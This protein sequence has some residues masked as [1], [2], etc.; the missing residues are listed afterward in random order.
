MTASL[1][2]KNTYR[3]AVICALVAACIMAAKTP[4]SKVLLAGAD[5]M[6]A[7]VF[8]G[9]GAALGMLIVMFFARNTSLVDKTRHLQKSDIPYLCGAILTSIGGSLFLLFGLLDAAASTASL[10]NNFGT[11]ATAV[12]AFLI[13]KEGISKR[14]CIGIVFTV[15]GC[16]ALSVTD[17][18]TLSF[19]PGS[20]LIILS[21]I[22]YGFNNNFM[23]KISH[24]NPVEIVIVRSGG[25]AVGCLI[26][27]F[28][29]GSAMPS[30]TTIALLAATGFV[31]SG[32][33]NFFVVYAQRY[34]GAA[35]TSAIT[36]IAPL[37]SVLICFVFLGEPLSLL[38]AGALIL[39][40]PGMY[41]TLTRNKEMKLEE[42]PEDKGESPLL[43]G[44]SEATKDE[45]RHYLMAF[46]FISLAVLHIMALFSSLT[47]SAVDGKILSVIG[48]GLYS[49]CSVIGIA[50][51]L[52]SIL[53]LILRKRVIP[54]ILFM[55]FGFRHIA[56]G[57]S[58]GSGSIS[59]SL[60]V[61]GLILGLILL[62][63]NDKQKYVYAGLIFL[64]TLQVILTFVGNT[65]AVYIVSMILMALVVLILLY[66][67]V[68]S[69]SQK[70]DMPLKSYI[71]ADSSVSFARC[72]VILG[73]LFYGSY[74]LFRLVLLFGGI[75]EI[76]TE[77]LT[78]TGMVFA[79]MLVLVSLLLFFIA[80]RC[81][82]S[83][84]FMCLGFIAIFS[85]YITS[86]AGCLTM[87]LL[88]LLVAVF[89]VFRNNS[90]LLFSLLAI[91][92]AFSVTIYY[93]FSQVPGLYNISI[94]LDAF[95]ILVCVYLAAAVLSEKK[96]LPVF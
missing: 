44:M 22:C 71:T 8:N 50:L 36:A 81:F 28:I 54:A 38:F 73:F 58:E 51:I 5:P 56:F 57:V 92:Q 89:A 21:C 64:Y 76:E 29:Y 39:V 77:V 13:F 48:D 3:F 4:V 88:L 90:A 62:T 18:T 66:F 11:V 19:T 65:G 63:V 96:E 1:N 83:I 87:S 78:H 31:F 16:I 12:I 82:Y 80:K 47:T 53:L 85:H 41:F 27:A 15:L 9:A 79:G 14:L 69:A 75:E 91:T 40:L 33:L 10:I 46:G 23:K 7:S 30:F 93:M 61:F 49:L 24:R 17:L 35:K 60:M 95:C 2:I 25:I 42:E 94:L 45:A 32:G 72:G 59:L 43:A 6:T 26:A 86:G 34:V 20:L 52:C 74:L 84:I 68:V 67:A 37:I 70:Y 55:F